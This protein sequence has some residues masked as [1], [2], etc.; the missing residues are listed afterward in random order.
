M[1][2]GAMANQNLSFE[3]KLVLERRKEEMKKRLF[4]FEMYDEDEGIERR[5]KSK[6]FKNSKKEIKKLRYRTGIK[7]VEIDCDFF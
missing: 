6:L 5:R 2:G 7:N 3:D 1:V 4:G